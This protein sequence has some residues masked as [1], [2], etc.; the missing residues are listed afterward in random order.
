MY[1]KGV[2][3]MA[4]FDYKERF[5]EIF[6]AK[7]VNKYQVYQSVKKNVSKS[8]YYSIVNGNTRDPKYPAL[9]EI[10]SSVD[11]TISQLYDPEYHSFDIPAS[12]AEFIEQVSNTDDKTFGRLVGYF[13][14]LV[15][16]K[17]K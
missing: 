14:S 12:R 13:D 4:E 16:R 10:C 5:K 9:Y 11:I 3:T 7:G 17:K 8:A 15:A 2:Y 1:Y 6:A